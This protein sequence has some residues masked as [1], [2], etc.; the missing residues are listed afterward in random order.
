MREGGCDVWIASIPEFAGHSAALARVLVP[1]ERDYVERSRGRQVLDTLSRGLLRLLLARY[2]EVAPDRIEID[3]T[4]PTCG[5][6]HSKPRLRAADDAGSAPLH[7]S[8]AH[9]GDL[10]V[11]AVAADGP[12]GVDVEPRTPRQDLSGELLELT[13]TPT[14]RLRVEQAPPGERWEVF[15]HYW[16]GKEAVLKA[17]GTGLD[18]DPNAVTLPSLLSWAATPVTSPSAPPVSLWLSSLCVDQAYVCTLAVGREGIDPRLTRLP[19]EV[20]FAA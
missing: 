8:V 10:L 1:A 17:L 2:L 19:P 9:G 12:I 11:I 5:A 16:T 6:P 3:R 4:C 13:L 15:L 7:F 20:L 18:L 14:E